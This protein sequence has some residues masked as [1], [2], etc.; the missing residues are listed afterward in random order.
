MPGADSPLPSQ[1]TSGVRGWREG[2]GMSV[3]SLS[4]A[5]DGSVRRIACLPDPDSR[6]HPSELV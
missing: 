5:L 6:D 1:M 3:R 4:G 2:I